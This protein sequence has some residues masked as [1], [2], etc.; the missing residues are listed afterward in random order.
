M[1]GWGNS[2]RSV[3]G[4]RSQNGVELYEILLLGIGCD[5]VRWPK[6]SGI[7]PLPLRLLDSDA[8][9]ES[10]CKFYVGMTVQTR[11]LSFL[12]LL[13]KS[14]SKNFHCCQGSKLQDLDPVVMDQAGRWLGKR[15][16]LRVGLSW[17]LSAWWEEHS[18]KARGKET[19]PGKFEV[20]TREILLFTKFV[21]PEIPTLW[22][23][24]IYFV[25]RWSAQLERGS[26]AVEKWSG[27]KRRLHGALACG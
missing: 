9:F 5:W 26:F 21:L 15:G 1:P 3:G 6:I 27:G 22:M 17:Q 18:R 16:G 10:L 13:P 25:P 4:R 7:R 2:L 24:M 14:K 12:T 19:P 8:A 23:S 20:G 11:H